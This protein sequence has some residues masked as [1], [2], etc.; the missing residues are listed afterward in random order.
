[1]V[2]R[3]GIELRREHVRRLE[4]ELARLDEDLAALARATREGAWWERLL[5]GPRAVERVIELEGERSD[6]ELAAVCERVYRVNGRV[7]RDGDVWIWRGEPDPRP[8][9]VEVRA[10]RVE[11]RTRVTTRDGGAPRAQY[12]SLLAHV[13]VAV[14]SFDSRFLDI[15]LFWVVSAVGLGGLMRRHTMRVARRKVLDARELVRA[16]EVETTSTTAVRI[17][18]HEEHSLEVEPVIARASR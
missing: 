17:D 15:A 10:E 5:G 11:G 7:E 3:D 6:D 9:R 14:A 2:Y 1:M 13:I 8:R 16:L 4:A 18:D 12:F